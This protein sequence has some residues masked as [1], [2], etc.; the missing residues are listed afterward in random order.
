MNRKTKGDKITDA[1]IIVLLIILSFVFIY[2]LWFV[3]I[4]SFS[5]PADIAL[6]R[7]L[8]VPVG[9]NFDGYTSMYSHPELFRGYLNSI[10]YLFGG[11]F[12]QLAVI[13]PGGYALS[14]RELVGRRVFNTLFVI[15][16]YFG[17][18]MIAVFLLHS[19]IGWINT[20]WVMVIPAAL[21]VYNMILARSSFE[22]LP[23][24]LRESAMIDG[25]SDFRYFFQFAVPLCKATV[26]VL[27]LFSAVGWWNEYMRFVIY[28]SNPKIQTLQVIIRNITSEIT[29]TLSNEEA[30]TDEMI[31][32]QRQ[33]E[34]LRYSVV[35]IAA[36][37]FCILYPFI[38]KYFNKGVMIGAV[39]G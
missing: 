22:S 11:S 8:I 3:V 35:V 18:G 14:R 27:F 13:L 30:T 23:E 39:K 5:N 9:F 24:S 7:V 33:M 31:E 17:G 6:G 26:A 21:N 20:I 32:A 4:A 19:T 16:M 1:A 36:L 15:T 29:K 28:V 12:L 38:Q 37:P 2:P 25:A 10:L 34:L